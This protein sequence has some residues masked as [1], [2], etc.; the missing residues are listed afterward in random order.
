MNR[1]E[2]VSHGV[3]TEHAYR[4]DFNGQ[5]FIYKQWIDANDKLIDDAVTDL[6]G[7]GVDNEDDL[8]NIFSDRLL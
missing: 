5:G 7:H 1:I 6:Y 2:I 3:T 8:L 4:L